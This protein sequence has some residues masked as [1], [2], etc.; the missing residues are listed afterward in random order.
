[1]VTCGQISH[2]TLKKTFK[3]IQK[4]IA[5][6]SHLA[7]AATRRLIAQRA[8]YLFGLSTLKEG[9]GQWRIQGGVYAPR[10]LFSL[11]CQYMKIPVD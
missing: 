5:A 11:A 9:G 7:S 10:G 8:T 4:T 6:M 3:K 2:K 1:M